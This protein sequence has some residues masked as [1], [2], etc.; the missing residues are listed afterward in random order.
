MR[1]NKLASILLVIVLAVCLCTLFV[2]CDDGNTPN[3]D[4]GGIKSTPTIIAPNDG[5]A[6]TEYCVTVL[7]PDRTPVV[8]AEVQLFLVDDDAEPYSGA[9]TGSDGV[10]VINT[11]QEL[12]YFIVVKGLQDGYIYE[13]EELILSNENTKTVIVELENA[14]NK[15]NISVVTEGGMKMENVTVSLKDGDNALA[16]KLTDKEGKV[17]LKVGQLGTYNVELSGL[18]TGYSMMD[19]NVT[20]SAVD[21]DLTVTVKS[22]VISEKM[23][24]NY[25]YKMD[26]IMYD[27]SIP[28]SDGTTFKLSEVLKEKDFVMINFW[29]TWCSP[30][31]AEFEGMQKAYERYKDNMAIIAISVDDTMAEVANFKATYSPTLT[32][33]MGTDPEKLYGNFSTYSQG[34][35]P[36]T[37]FVDR[38]GKI[39]NF[40][41][42]GGT[43]ALFRQEFAHY[44]AE[45]YVQ[46]PYDPSNDKVPVEEADKPEENMPESSTIVSA[47]SPELGGTYSEIGD[48]TTWPWYLGKDGDFDV[49]YAGNIK[50]N[51]TSSV[52]QYTFKLNAGEFLT[53]DYK[54]NTEDIGNADILGV[55]IDNSWMCDLDRVTDGWQT[56]Y[57]YTPL[58]ASMDETDADKEH[59]LMLYYVKDASDGYLKGDEVVSIKNIRKVNQADIAKDADVNIL[60]EASWNYDSDLKQWTSYAKVVYNELDGYY[61]VGTADGP[62]LLANIGAGTHYHDMSVSAF[63]ASGYF[64]LANIEAQYNFITAG[65]AKPPAGSY[66]EYQKG[67]AWMAVNSD[68][69]NYCLVDKTLKNSLDVIVEA[70]SKT[71]VNGEFLSTYYNENTWLEFCKYYDNYSGNTIGNILTGI[72]N[73]EAIPAVDGN[74][75]NHVVV[76][77]TLVPRGIMYKYTPEVSGA[78]K[79]YSII[80]KEYAG[81]QGGYVYITG[82]NVLKSEDAIGDFEQYVT[83]E[84]GE[85]YYIGVA[86]DLPGSWGELDFYIEYIGASQ[87]YFTYASDGT[88]TYMIDADGNPIYV[89]GDLVYIINK[90]NNLQVALGEDGKYHQVL[91][92]GSIDTGSKS[93]IWISLANNSYLLD[94]TIKALATGAATVD[95]LD[96]PFF[97]FTNEGGEDYTDYIL[98]LITASEKQDANSETYGMVEADE[99][100]VMVLKKALARI[101]HN[102]DESWLGV[103]FYYEHL[104]EYPAK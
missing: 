37:I 90:N 100:L 88:Y 52:L 35:V 72:C 58:S 40:I 66:I 102:S 2:A 85:T 56:K 55:Y 29:A 3:P 14:T 18:P 76:N 50:H 80:P 44:T 82:K 10:A 47:I 38:Y 97:D 71:K 75:A 23:P 31:K 84:A 65:L 15:Y 59:T 101:G 8:G 62:Y 49:L 42:G 30:C 24:A 69:P 83:F 4:D 79:V 28:T 61:H 41:K 48:G 6:K 46:V 11:A 73:K 13:D 7:Y 32:F 5:L 93:T 99:K 34:A 78:Y 92:D 64:T 86:F 89:D 9:T 54:I 21:T 67:Y 51:N 104:G 91:A 103:A 53:F 39:C 74:Q 94:C 60:R 26:D 70:F 16:S 77:K 98:G 95:G 68:L 87:D 27:F 17:T 33:D 43:E 25:R 22:Q 63:S 36:T 12:E 81:K 1:K 96:Y 19:G 45:D 20:T 57:V